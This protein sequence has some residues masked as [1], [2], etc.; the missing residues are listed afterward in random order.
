MARRIVPSSTRLL[1]VF[2]SLLTL[3][4]YTRVLAQSSAHEVTIQLLLQALHERSKR[5]VGETEMRAAAEQL[6]SDLSPEHREDLL[7]GR[8]DAADVIDARSARPGRKAGSGVR[9]SSGAAVGDAKS[10]LLFVPLPPC[11]VF[12]TRQSFEGIITAGTTRNFVVAGDEHFAHQGGSADGCGVPLGNWVTGP[13]AAA[14]AVNLIA[15]S[16]A[17]PGFLK[18]WE[19]AQPEPLASVINFAAIGTNLANGV[20]LPIEGTDAEAFDLAIEGNN[21]NV[22]VVADVSGYFTR[23][24]VED[25]SR[26][27]EFVSNTNHPLDLTQCVQPLTCTVTTPRSSRIVVDGHVSIH[28]EH[29]E[30]LWDRASVNVETANPPTCPVHPG[31]SSLHQIP[32]AA[33][34]AS[35]WLVSVPIHRVFYQVAGSTETYRLTARITS[36]ASPLDYVDAARMSCLVIPE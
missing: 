6:A 16:P 3:G 27:E 5:P 24:P 36:G 21:S 23:L 34:S 14:V 31:L 20:I 2:A 33:P 1:L 26:V 18:A 13:I 12:D 25:L 15:V 19:Y 10:H 9:Q 30:G 17:G 11:R 7:A 4:G 8:L 28:I 22:H 32:S 29:S 35:T